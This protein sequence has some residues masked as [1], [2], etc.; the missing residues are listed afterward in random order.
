MGLSLRS[1][2]ACHGAVP[3]TA[4]ESRW[5]AP[6]AGSV[7]GTRPARCA[8]PRGGDPRSHRIETYRDIIL[9]A[10][11]A[12]VDITLV[13][14]SQL[15][16]DRHGAAIALSTIWRFLDRHAM[17]IGKKRHTPASRHGPTSPRGVRLGSTLRPVS[18]HA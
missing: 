4:S 7:I 17:T 11:D 5:P 9:A 1:K 14:L 13:E 12:K 16:R 8:K 10:V 6:F 15:L 3:P 18:H 2:A